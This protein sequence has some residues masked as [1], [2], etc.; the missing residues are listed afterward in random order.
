[1]KIGLVQREIT[2]NDPAGNLFGT[3]E[4]MSRLIDQDVNLICL[5]ELWATGLI[6]PT[7]LQSSRLTSTLDGPTVTA[8]REFCLENKIYLLAG[9]LA[10][11]EKDG[12]KNQ[13]L[14]IDQTGKIKRA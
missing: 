9:S 5:S 7:E 13:A 1:M 2:P 12:L 11:V 4:T 14:L 6:D 10:M 3:L 8:L